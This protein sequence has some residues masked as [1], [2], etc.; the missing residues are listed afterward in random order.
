[1]RLKFCRTHAKSNT[2]DPEEA[3]MDA[4][5]GEIGF[6]PNFLSPYTKGKVSFDKIR[7]VREAL[8]PDASF[9]AAVIAFVKT[10][11]SPCL[12]VVAGLG[13]RKREEATISQDVFDFVVQPVK[14][15]RAL[16]TSSNE[17]ARKIGL[18][19]P[20]NMRIPKKSIIWEVFSNG[21][22]DGQAIEDLSWW[23]DS[24][25]QSLE[26]REVFTMAAKNGGRVL[27]LI[28]PAK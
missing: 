19:V 26:P 24:S 12:L 20:R 6:F 15:L 5:A 1:M 4:I 16:Q 10:W 18:F 17:M 21:L 11:Q 13:W 3:V 9:Q 8:C 2:K 27:A 25:G 22:S 23:E 14:E 7:E 28:V